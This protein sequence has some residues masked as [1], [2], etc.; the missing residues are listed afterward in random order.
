[1]EL[2]LDWITNLPVE[3]GKKGRQPSIKVKEP[4]NGGD[5]LIDKKGFIYFSEEFKTKVDKQ[6]LDFVFLTDWLEAKA[7]E[8]VEGLLIAFLPEGTAKASIKS[9]TGCSLAFLSKEFIPALKERFDIDLDVLETIELKVIDT[10]LKNDN[11]IYHF[12][13][14]VS[15]GEFKGTST[16][17]RRENVELF[18]LDIIIPTDV[19]ES[20]EEEGHQPPDEIEIVK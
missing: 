5:I 1:M 3:D 18:P 9:K 6:Y 10:E 14:L 2:N 20:S 11:S 8:G 7:P 19:V 12:N 16:P 13:K 17:V 15:T 4:V